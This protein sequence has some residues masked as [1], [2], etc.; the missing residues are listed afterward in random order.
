[1]EADTHN[2]AFTES[3]V[4]EIDGKIRCRHIEFISKR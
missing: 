3:Y 1:M 4:V 2:A